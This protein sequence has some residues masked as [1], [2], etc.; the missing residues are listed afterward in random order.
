MQ[1]SKHFRILT[2]W[3]N[4]HLIILGCFS[5]EGMEQIEGMSFFCQDCCVSRQI[6]HVKEKNDYAEPH[7]L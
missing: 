4:P 3:E 2:A 6:L 7:S 5:P 1:V